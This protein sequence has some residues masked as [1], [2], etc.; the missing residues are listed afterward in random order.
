MKERK[1]NIVYEKSFRFAV[2]IVNFYKRLIEEEKEVVLSKQLLRA[3]TSIGANVHEALEGQS[4]KDFVAK[5]AIA[6]KEAAETEYWL[7]LLEA[8]DFMKYGQD[9][10]ELKR[11]ASEMIRLLN[12]II[13]TTKERVN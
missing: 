6:L 11:D 9:Y 3:G 13:K 1:N 5:L 2:K 10:S 7:E 8:T 4:K 12:A